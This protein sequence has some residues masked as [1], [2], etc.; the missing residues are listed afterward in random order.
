MTLLFKQQIYVYASHSSV[1]GYDLVAIV[2]TLDE[3]GEWID[4]Y[5]GRNKSKVTYIIDGT[6][7]AWH[8]Q[9]GECGGSSICDCGEV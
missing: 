6:P 7:E 3:A 2:D 9:T 4:E 8:E 1:D 5:G